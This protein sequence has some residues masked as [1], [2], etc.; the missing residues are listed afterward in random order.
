MIS[1]FVSNA[2][3]T[4]EQRTIEEL[5]DLLKSVSE[6]ASTVW[7]D[8][9]EP[10]AEEEDRVLRDIF[11][12]HPLTILDCRRER[13]N[14]EH[15][16]HLPKVEDFREYLFAIINAIE[17]VETDRGIDGEEGFDV[18]TR[19]LNTYLGEH[20]IVTHHY[21]PSPPIKET[22]LLCQKNAQLLER[23]PDYIY[24]LI[25]DNIVDEY[26]PILDRFD[27]R[28]EALED[29]VFSSLNSR[30]LPSILDMKRQVFRL[31]R[32]TTYQR[33][34][35]YRLSRGEFPLVSE[36]EIA[37]YRNVYDHLVRATELAESYRDILT[38]LLDAYLSMTSNRMNEVMK[39]LTIIST[40]FLPLTF[41]AGV[42]GM[43]FEFMPELHWRYGYLF[44]WGLMIAIAIVM[45]IFF[46]RRR[47]I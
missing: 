16:H 34:M 36:K 8:L 41:I 28:I 47:W 24:H 33:E 43:N 29:D 42:Y 44:V 2:E 7:V 15:G 46:K 19:Q 18:R 23:G 10:T 13:I 14:P 12:F 9:N 5:P 30:T 1:I 32:I 22:G 39:V 40:F 4:L 26:S 45:F 20:F 37:Y 35:V 21:E 31:R 38:G 27:H 25:L 3:H 6:N 17:L 11:E